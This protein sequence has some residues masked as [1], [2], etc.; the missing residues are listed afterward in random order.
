MRILLFPGIWIL[1]GGLL[2][3][4]LVLVLG[5]TTVRGFGRIAIYQSNLIEQCGFL[6]QIG[7]PW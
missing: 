5:A 7:L 3:G 2:N 4:F 1:D 6:L